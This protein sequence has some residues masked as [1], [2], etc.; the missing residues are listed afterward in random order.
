MSLHLKKAVCRFFTQLCGWEKDVQ[1]SVYQSSQSVQPVVL[2]TQC[3]LSSFCHWSQTCHIF[4]TCC[5][6]SQ[7]WSRCTL[8]RE[9]STMGATCSLTRDWI[10]LVPRPS[11]TANVV[12]GP[13]KLLHRMTSAGCTEGWHFHWTAVL[14]HARCDTPCLRMSTWHHSTNVGVL[15]GLTLH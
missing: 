4:C 9:S 15:P 8:W 1:L 14:V 3:T 6:S 12:E 5:H 11:I 13:V 10:S 2:L 7:I